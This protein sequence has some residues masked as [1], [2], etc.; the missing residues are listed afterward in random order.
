VRILTEHIPGVRSAAVGIWVRQGAAHETPEQMGATHLLE[1]M[2]FKGTERR[3]PGEIALALE[4]LGGSLDA[5][6]AREHTSFQARVLDAHVP[7]AL[8]VLTDLACHPLLRGEDLTLEREVVLEEIAQVEDTPD[9]L[10]HELHGARLWGGHPY[11]HHILGTRD[12]VGALSIDDLRALHRERYV[13]RNLVVAAAGNVEHGDFVE[14]VAHHLGDR[15]AGAPGAEVPPP[16]TPRAGR[17]TVPRPTAQAHLVAGTP[18]VPHDHA[19]RIPLILLSQAFGGGMSS[20]LF[21]RIREE[22]GLVYTVYSFQSFYTRSGIA[23]VYL[24]TRPEWLARAEAALLEEYARLARHGLSPEEAAQT[25]RQ[26]K[27][28]IMLSL[29]STSARLYRLAGFA[30]HDEEWLDLDGLLARVDAVSDDQLR[31]AAATW[32]DPDRQ[33][34]LVLGPETDPDS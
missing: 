30:L 18:G 6:T 26:V 17:A 20:R 10:V 15:P 16:P 33:L 27:G 25:R 2:V 5:Y 22:L 29:E 28:Q 24:G 14:R 13:G 12:T 34:R 32:F 21:Q 8:D 31:E 4:S 9:D 23:G 1:H 3:T 7:E 19:M 11:G